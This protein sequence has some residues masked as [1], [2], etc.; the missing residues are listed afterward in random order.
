MMDVGGTIMTK[1]SK[2]EQI[3]SMV[4]S[5]VQ[6]GYCREKYSDET[7]T[8]L[9][10]Y[11]VCPIREHTGGFEHHC[12]RGKIKIAQGILEGR[13][14]Y[15]DELIEVLY[16]EPDCK[17]CSYICHAEPIL[18]PVKIWRTMR[19]DIVAAGLGPPQ[20]LKKIDTRVKDKHNVF[21]GKQEKRTN[22]A[23][24]IDLPRKGDTLYF[25][26]CHA[27]YAKRTIARSTVAIMKK[28]GIDVAYLGEDEWCCGV[29]QF[30][31]GST[32]IAE[33]MARHNVEAI[34]ATGARRVI[35]ACAECFK[36]LKVEYPAIIGELPF[37]VV[38]ISEEILE[39]LNS[40][41]LELTHKLDERKIT[42]HDPCQLGRYCKVYESPR[43]ILQRIPGVDLIEM[44]RHHGN[45]WCCGNGA[46]MVRSMDKDLA[47][48]IAGD[49]L[50]EASEAGVEMI[51][52]SCPRCIEAFERVSDEIKIL[53]LSVVVAQAMAIE[54]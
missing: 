11:R 36:S 22:W 43:E 10:A 42:Y 30:H 16:T 50:N 23:G 40:G 41:K 49:R 27:T 9:T 15:S 2:L 45:A 25:A 3:K 12:A 32:N 6:C 31:D 38:H 24:D 5:C 13:F 1:E 14:S 33:D 4:Y 53:D 46:D 8:N 34:K 51:V 54:I 26:G 18:D 37:E 29:V 21:G 48:E 28:A 52:T 17:L 39:L 7:F 20:P 47:I 44:L 35:T 19:E